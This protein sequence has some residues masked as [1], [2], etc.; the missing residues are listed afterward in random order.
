LDAIGALD[1]HITGHGKFHT[2]S[3]NNPWWMVDLDEVSELTE[4]RIYNRIL[5]KRPENAIA[6]R[7]ARLKIEGGKSIDALEEFFRKEDNI[8]FGGVDGKPLIVKLGGPRSARFIR[9]TLLSKNPM[10]FDQ[11]EVYGRKTVEIVI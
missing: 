11:V 7:A 3:E 10:H 2:L 6:A 8:P 9:I 1:G 5:P 4:I